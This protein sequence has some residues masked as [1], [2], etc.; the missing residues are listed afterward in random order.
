MYTV[1][2]DGPQASKEEKHNVRSWNMDESP[3]LYSKYIK[4]ETSRTHSAIT[5]SQTCSLIDW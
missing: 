1:S 2:S 5:A 4:T 3:E